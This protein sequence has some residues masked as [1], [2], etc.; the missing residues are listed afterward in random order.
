MQAT[1]IVPLSIH[2][3]F[4]SSKEITEYYDSVIFNAA[5]YVYMGHK[6]L[7]GSSRLLI[8]D[9]LPGYLPADQS[10]RF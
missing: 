2:N 8:D 3:S 5:K 10:C 1:L 7:W 4:H 9:I 6:T